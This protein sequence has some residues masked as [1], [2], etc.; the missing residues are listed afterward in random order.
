MADQIYFTDGDFYQCV[1]VTSP[2]ETP[3]TAPSKWRKI[4]LLAKWRWALAQLTYA[5][6]LSVDGQTDKAQIETRRA[7]AQ[8]GH[9]LD[10]L[11]RAEAHEEEKRHCHPRAGTVHPQSGHNQYVKASVVL[12]DAYRLMGWDADQLDA[13]DFG[14]ARS[15]LSQALQEVWERW[16]WA[17]LMVCVPVQFAGNWLAIEDYPTPACYYAPAGKYYL[18]T[19]D[20]LGAPADAAGTVQAGWVEYDPGE[21]PT[22]TAGTYALNDKVLHAGQYWVSSVDGNADVPAAGSLWSNLFDAAGG[23]WQ[24]TLPDP[25][26]E[27]TLGQVYGPIR[28]VAQFDPRTARNP[29]FFQLDN[30]ADGTRVLGLTV[31]HPWVW[32]RRVTP[33]L[34][35]DAYDA[36]A[37]YEATPT[38]NLVFDT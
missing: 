38:A 31:T 1:T 10:D 37:T 33:I 3:T 32:S 18:A 4:R 6:L 29:N 34:T 28:G 11:M 35:G 7:Y 16:W 8:D 26:T 14:D 23:D 20:S 15:A 22:W 2:G 12:D 17:Q 19:S 9:G 27:N 13:R 25:N 21:W 24:P 36:T 5:R 30:T